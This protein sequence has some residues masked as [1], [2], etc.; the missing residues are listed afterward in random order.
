MQSYV[1][2][3]RLLIITVVV[4]V[5][6]VPSVYFWHGFQVQVNAQSLKERAKRLADEAKEL[7]DDTEEEKEARQEKF[8]EAADW[9]HRYIRL[10]SGDPDAI[11]QRAETYYESANTLVRRRQAADHLETAVSVTSGTKS[12]ELAGRLAKLRFELRQYDA[13]KRAAEKVLKDDPSNADALAV[14]AKSKY[15]DEID[16]ASGKSTEI[17]DAAAK[18]I[19]EFLE[20]AIVANPHDRDLYAKLVD[21]YRERMRIR[22]PGKADAKMREMLA[23]LEDPQNPASR[24]E[25]ALGHLQVYQY[26]QYY[27]LGNADAILQKAL[28]IDPENVAVLLTRGA[29]LIAKEQFDASEK[30]LNK[31]IELDPKQ[32]AGYLMLASVLQNRKRTDQAIA[33]LEDG[34]EQASESLLLNFQLTGLLLDQNR[35]D[36][37]ETSLKSTKRAINKAA[38]YASPNVRTR[39]NHTGDALQA[40]LWIL[41]NKPHKAIP[42]LRTVT[43]SNPITGP[44]AKDPIRWNL[45]L[46]QAYRQAGQ[47]DQAIAAYSKITKVD[48]SN[49]Q[50][51]VGL[52]LAYSNSGRLEEAAK[53]YERLTLDE[54]IPND[55]W[56]LVARERFKKV[57]A[58]PTE[59]GWKDMEDVLQKAREKLPNNSQIALLDAQTQAARGRIPEAVKALDEILAKPNDPGRLAVLAS[60]VLFYDEWEQPAKAQKCLDELKSTEGL[61]P[62]LITQLEIDLLNQQGKREQALEKMLALAEQVDESKQ[63]DQLLWEAA[64]RELASGKVDQGRNR[65]RELAQQN[66]ETPRYQMALAELALRA[67]D[68]KQVAVHEKNLEKIEGSGGSTWRLFRI[69]R[70]LGEI[71]EGLPVKEV[72]KDSRFNEAKSLSESLKLARPSW[73]MTYLVEGQIEERRGNDD[74][75]LKRYVEA[76]QE[77]GNELIYDA[78][79]ALLYRKNRMTEA[80]QILANAPTNAKKSPALAL[81]VPDI[82][83][84]TGQVHKAVD[85]A[86]TGVKLRPNSPINHIWLGQALTLSMERKASLPEAEKLRYEAEGAFQRAVDLIPDDIRAH[87]AQLWFYNRTNQPK[88][89]QQALQRMEGLGEDS[90]TRY[91]SLANAAVL[92]ND[93]AGAEEYLRK[94]KD[95]AD[96]VEGGTG[97]GTKRL[98]ARQQLVQLLLPRKPKKAVPILAEMAAIDPKNKWVKRTQAVLQTNLA[99]EANKDGKANLGGLIEN[100]IPTSGVTTDEDDKRLKVYLLAKEDTKGSRQKAIEELKSLVRR[101]RPKPTDRLLLARFYELNDQIEEA[102]EEFQKVVTPRARDEQETPSSYLVAYIQFLL[103]VAGDKERP[104]ELR[105]S[106]AEKAK[107]VIGRL[108]LSEP[109]SPRVIFLQ[110]KASEAQTGDTSM[111]V[112]RIRLYE[113]SQLDKAGTSRAKGRVLS[114]IAQL[115]RAF[116]LTDQVQATL[117]KMANRGY[118]DRPYAPLALWLGRQ[119]EHAKAVQLC[120]DK[121]N[122][123]PDTPGAILLCSV[124]TQ[125]AGITEKRYPEA[126]KALEKQVNADSDNARLLFDVATMYYMQGRNQEA[127]EKYR[128]LQRAMPGNVLALNNLALLVS[129]DVSRKQESLELIEAAVRLARD[130]QQILDSKVLVLLNVGRPQ[131]ARDLMKEVIIESKK[132]PAGF[133]LHLA[134][135]HLRC[136]EREEAEKAVKDGQEAGL[137]RELLTP[138]ERS[139]LEE[140]ENE[141]GEILAKG[142]SQSDEEPELLNLPTQ[143]AAPVRPTKRSASGNSS[144][145]SSTRAPSRRPSTRLSPPP[146]SPP[147]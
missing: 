104:A 133:Y 21:L 60:A 19:E 13:A 144:R 117:E 9:Y 122:A 29:D 50:A 43:S 135:A 92:M 90:F 103:R 35:L 119:G 14:R 123:N 42:V 5:V 109:D 145:S 20:E 39:L 4:L 136:G 120:L 107:G 61:N 124:L 57:E 72:V 137:Q 53:E 10:R 146:L 30:V 75:A 126:E 99:R 84:R 15:N 132:V 11:V 73:S 141:F 1:V 113:A 138:R 96:I 76:V 121:Y 3:I 131:E 78:L 26:R 25:R 46:G 116:D 24:E 2:N 128:R 74:E 70:L 77:G 66:P 41:Q 48:K 56:V 105:N 118:G 16:E 115:F 23:A 93:P 22:N 52:A 88:R 139:M 40:R 27:K 51:R 86:R 6:A 80:A 106:M 83:V 140:L 18:E 112:D 54:D 111:V 12:V 38:L 85:I 49:R 134:T 147:R 34:I 69:L 32:P 125:A 91:L 45:L 101:P 97:D 33:R 142:P 89:A 127:E 8:Q 62:Q 64:L 130:S 31:V 108:A 44:D 36:K 94:A 114:V 59:D 110:C 95:E 87:A 7:P 98:A 143:R 55:V 58:R 100:L 82:L 28:E 37:A 81:M 79:I 67:E 63:R 17:E 129:E 47:W 71:P 102:D 68:Y 65:I